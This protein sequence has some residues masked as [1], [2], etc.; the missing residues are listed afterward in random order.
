MTSLLSD[1]LPAVR[2]R[3][4]LLALLSC[5]AARATEP[6]PP[7]APKQELA[8]SLALPATRAREPLPEPDAVKVR[9]DGEYEAR[10]AFLT[11]LPLT[12]VAG[13]AASLGQTSRLYHWLRLRGLGLFG[14]H[15]ELRAEADFPRGLI[16]A[17]LPDAVPD[18]GTDFDRE[19]PV[20]FHP[21]LFR[22]TLRG[23]LG[24]VSLGHTTAQIGMGLVDSDGDQ[25]R[26]FGTPDVPATYE[27]VQLWSGSSDSTLRIG[28][29]A[30]VLA[31][32]GRL[33]LTDGDRLARVGLSAKYAPS[34]RAHLD[35]LA[36][37]ETLAKRDARGGAKSLL[38]DL[39][40]AFRSPIAGRAGEV[41]GEYEVAYR[42]GAVSEP[43]ALASGDD[44]ALGA[45]ALASRVGVALERVENYRRFAS[46][47]VSLEWGL[48][49]GDADP[50][51][52]ELHRFVMNP[53]HGVGMILFGEILRFKTS[54]AQARLASTDPAAGS[55][56]VEGL[57]TRGGVAGANYL[58]PV[59]LVRP[60]PDL[61]LKIGGVVASATTSVV[62]P[63]ALTANG[64]RQN[65]DGGTP[66]GRS[67]GTELDLGAELTLPLD[68]PLSV[69][70]S[71]EGAVAFPGSAFNAEN[72]RRLGTQALTLAGLGLTF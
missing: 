24:E 63:G 26:W 53:N 46:L 7:P 60:T 62:D 49:S 34:P 9:L 25:P 50:T 23:R 43:T 12:P 51:D 3:A 41:F 19:Q 38:F 16:Y 56:R 67:L 48:A 32:D 40:G 29:A 72:G 37:Y 69:R 57:A 27:R 2:I 6:P 61:A 54:R 28:G 66:R 65:F 13:S 15:W 31:S 59:V 11:A 42:V 36:R 70:L 68:A 10:Q 47:V 64:V 18:N 39:S 22:L 14:T 17:K 55:A 45:L 5:A 33:S 71:L 21:R 35:L 4:A 44:Q 30:D 8:E 58:N 52:D 20:R 1:S